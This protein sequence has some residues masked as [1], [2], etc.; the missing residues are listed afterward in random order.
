MSYLEHV[1]RCKC[2]GIKPLTYCQY[3]NVI[4]N[5]SQA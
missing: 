3:L 1:W 5:R 2:A 4:N